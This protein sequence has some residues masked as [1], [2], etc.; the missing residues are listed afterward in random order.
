MVLEQFFWDV[1]ESVADGQKASSQGKFLPNPRAEFSSIQ[2]FISW[3]I[4]LSFGFV[5][6]SPILMALTAFW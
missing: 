6:L 2:Q 1:E 3:G 4:I 5:A